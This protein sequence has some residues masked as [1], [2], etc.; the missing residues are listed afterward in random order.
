MHH[1]IKFERIPS[2]YAILNVHPLLKDGSGGDALWASGHEAYDRLSLAFKVFAGTL[3]ATH[4]QYNFNRVT[5]QC[6]AE[7]I[8]NWRRWGARKYRPRLSNLSPSCPH[9]SS[10]EMEEFVW[11]YTSGRIWLDRRSK[12]P[13]EQ[14][15]GGLCFCNLLRKIM[16]YKFVFGGGE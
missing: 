13:R 11:C 7:F 5:K 8:D 14:D 9:E 2:D 6:G 3:T 10:H 12:R 15:S 4:Y 1:S 16:T